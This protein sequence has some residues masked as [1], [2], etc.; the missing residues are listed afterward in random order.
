MKSNLKKLLDATPYGEERGLGWLH[1]QTGITHRLLNG[2]YGRK[3][4]PSILDALKIAQAMNVPVEAIW[5]L[6][7][8]PVENLVKKAKSGLLCHSSA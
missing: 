3:L 2:Y 4:K 1:Q 7:P 6:S 5:H 8:I